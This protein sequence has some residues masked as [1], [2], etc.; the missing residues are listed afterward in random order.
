M[1]CVYAGLEPLA[2]TNHFPTW[3]VYEEATNANTEENRPSKLEDMQSCFT[4]LSKSVY[5][6]EELQQRPLPDGVNPNKLETYLSDE[7]FMV[8]LQFHCNLRRLSWSNYTVGHIIVHVIRTFRSPTQHALMQGTGI[9]LSQP[10]QS[11]ALNSGC[12]LYVQWNG[13]CK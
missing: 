7:Q 3:E 1:H 13:T 9:L 8:R 12:R 4:Q 5:T 11:R 2:F 6:F 10:V